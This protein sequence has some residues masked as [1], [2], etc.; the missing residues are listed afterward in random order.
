MKKLYREAQMRRL[1]SAFYDPQHIPIL[2]L[3]THG[4]V[5]PQV[6]IKFVKHLVFIFIS[7]I[8]HGLI[9]L[10][11]LVIQ[12]S[13]LFIILENQLMILKV[14]STSIIKKNSKLVSGLMVCYM[15]FPCNNERSDSRPSFSEVAMLTMFA[16]IKNSDLGFKQTDI[17]VFDDNG[18]P[19]DILR[20]FYGVNINN[21]FGT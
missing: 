3:D 19:F 5:C 4:F 20:T 14:G 1:A 2:K 7:Q 12:L 16:T 9:H 18:E 11:W 10:D 17:I 6:M 8:L 15:R 21:P 13:D